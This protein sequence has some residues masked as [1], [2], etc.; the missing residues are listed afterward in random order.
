MLS[1]AALAVYQLVQLGPEA[2]ESG[3]GLLAPGLVTLAVGIAAGQAGRPGCSE[4]GPPDPAA[5]SRPGISRLAPDRPSPRPGPYR[6]TGHGRRGTVHLRA[7]GV[8][9][10]RVVPGEP[11]RHGGR[12]GHGR[13]RGGSLTAGSCHCDGAC[14][15]RRPARHAR[16]CLRHARDPARA[17]DHR[18]GQP[19][20]HLPLRL[21]RRMGKDAGRD[22]GGP[23]PSGRHP[24][25]RGAWNTVAGRRRDQTRLTHH[26][27]ACYSPRWT[28]DGQPA[29]L[30]LG[31]LE[32]G[33]TVVEAEHP[34]CVTGCRV[35]GL[36]FA[37]SPRGHRAGRSDG[38]TPQADR[39]RTR[40]R[41]RRS[42][43]GGLA[44]TS[45][46]G[47]PRAP[48]S[49]HRRAAVSRCHSCPES[50]RPRRSSMP[51]SRRQSQP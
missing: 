23:A 19:P 43:T 11:G 2:A 40:R 42:P 30:L 34:D 29:T 22:A 20:A 39:R 12:S 48:R 32:H 33:G 3:L 36:T 25:A 24:P 37:R 45:A 49:R 6:R 26:S 35:V 13:R 15:S 28:A 31:R 9:P 51:T 17:A 47:T 14:R 10:R 5:S 50:R 16:R 4:L 44:P 8:E 1:A 18:G 27:T 41:R 21:A 38:C 46:R 7:A